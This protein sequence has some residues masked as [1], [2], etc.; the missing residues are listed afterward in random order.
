MMVPE[1]LGQ[2][3]ALQSLD[4]RSN[5]LTTLPDWLGRLKLLE[6]LSVGDNKLASLPEALSQLTKLRVLGI[7]ANELTELPD[8]LGTLTRLKELYLDNPIRKLP[9]FLR[10]L[11][12]I[13]T[14]T[15]A[16]SELTFLPDWL[17]EL[18]ELRSLYV[19]GNLITDIPAEFAKL[20]KLDSINLD[21]NPLN[22]ELAAVYNDGLDAV[23]RYLR[24]KAE[25]QVILN[26]AKLILIGE[27]EV[28]KSCLLGALRGDEWVEK[29]DTTHG[30]EIKPVKANDPATGTE[31]TLNGWDFGGQ[32]VYR[33]THQLFFSAPA[34]YL[35]VWKPREGP[36]QGFVKEWLKL[37]KHR[38]RTRKS[39][40]SPRTVDPA[41]ASRTSIGRRFG[42][43]SAKRE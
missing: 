37:V 43:C 20:A 40:W 12:Q 15:A 31:I 33:P 24:A 23:K 28:G 21:D 19:P 4:L 9:A 1:W 6:R 5:Q 36:Q 35:V 8:S 17:S 39:W 16:R 7:W 2:L 26:E 13:K 3:K 25:A 11:T 41:H 27:G 22:S 42:T 34:V 10:N 32:R 18:Q 29:R 14:L 30:I 38:S